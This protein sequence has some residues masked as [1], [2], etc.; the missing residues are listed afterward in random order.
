MTTLSEAMT[1]PV[2]RQAV[3]RDAAALVE[4]EVASKRGLR[5]AALKTG[6]KAFQRVQ[7][8]IVPRAVERLL[9]HFVPAIEPLWAE[10]QASGDADAWFQQHD[11]RVGEALLAVT[12]GFAARAKNKVVLKIYR[13]LRGSA[14]E[15]VR[16]AVPR[17]PALIRAHTSA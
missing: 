4:S 10:A 6:F 15:H 8:G 7:P 2:R 1:D 16:A 9:P 13:G 17:L 14:E 11:A 5:G 3:V 12:D